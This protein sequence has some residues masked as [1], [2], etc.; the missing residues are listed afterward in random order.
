M[1]PRFPFEIIP[2][3][4]LILSRNDHQDNYSFCG[5]VYK[6]YKVLVG[7]AEGKRLLE[8]PRRRWEDGIRLDLRRLSWGV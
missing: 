8:R 5:F 2:F 6:V 4:Y 3:L 1:L 7:K